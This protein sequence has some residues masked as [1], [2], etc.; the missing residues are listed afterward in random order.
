VTGA[1]PSARRQDFRM[2][3]RPVRAWIAAV[4]P[5]TDLSVLSPIERARH[6]RLP[7]AADRARYAT[8]RVLARL[9]LA[10]ELGLT[11][12]TVPI[13]TGFLGRPGLDPELRRV[14][15]A[16]LDFNLSHSGGY[17]A[18]TVGR[19]VRV[20]V[21]IERIESRGDAQGLAVRYFG[22]AESDLLARSSAQRYDE[23]WYRIWT[24]REAHTKARGVGVRGI[25]AALSGHGS[26]WERRDLAVARGYV[27][28]LVALPRTVRA[29]P[30]DVPV[31]V[32]VPV[33]QGAIPTQSSRSQR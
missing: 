30:A 19:G 20:G 6:D 4:C 21:D 12:G 25:S 10:R 28:S 11:P 33:P 23:R 31:P 18:L 13:T 3:R 5:A 17:V 7:D 16:A 1:L 27:G 8:A 22:R 15:R 24:T 9:V 29:V 14:R 32:P 26:Q 2:C